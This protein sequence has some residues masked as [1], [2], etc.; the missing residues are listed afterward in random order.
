VRVGSI[1]GAHRAQQQDQAHGHAAELQRDGE[2]RS[3]GGART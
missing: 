2:E 3:D 1:G